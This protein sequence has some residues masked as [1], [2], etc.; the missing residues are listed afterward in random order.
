MKRFL[1]LTLLAILIAGT[2]FADYITPVS[3]GSWS[4]SDTLMNDEKDTCT[5][6]IPQSADVLT[7]DITVTTFGSAGADSLAAWYRCPVDGS[8]TTLTGT[9][10]VEPVT[11]I[12]TDGS[13]ATILNWTTT[14]NYTLEI[15]PLGC[16]YQQIILQGAA[17]DTILYILRAKVTDNQ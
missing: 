12:N 7:F 16:Q 13:S 5:F 6:V 10:S 2:A 15:D 14:N 17:T 4:V 9:G 8:T 1:F 3:G 11:F